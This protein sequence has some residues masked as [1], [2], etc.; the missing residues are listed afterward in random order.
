[1]EIKT[2]KLFDEKKLQK[3]WNNIQ[4]RLK[5]KR[6]SMKETG[7]GLGIKGSHNDVIALRFSDVAILHYVVAL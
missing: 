6:R 2:G 4:S 3:K 5:D 1:M 7:G